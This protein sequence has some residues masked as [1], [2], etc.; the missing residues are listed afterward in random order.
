MPRRTATQTASLNVNSNIRR[1][2]AILQVSRSSRRGFGRFSAGSVRDL[3][4]A[5]SAAGALNTRA[6]QAFERSP[7]LFDLSDLDFTADFFLV[8]GFRCGVQPSILRGK[9]AYVGFTGATGN[10][11][12]DHYRQLDF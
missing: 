8:R 9:P 5:Y 4:H 7:G 11:L 12:E 1:R 6:R 10:G 3:A 2:L